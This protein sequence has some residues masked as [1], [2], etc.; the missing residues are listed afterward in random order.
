MFRPNNN[1]YTIE[2]TEKKILTGK[3]PIIWKILR[4]FVI[5]GWIGFLFYNLHIWKFILA[6]YGRDPSNFVFFESEQDRQ[7]Y[8]Q[9]Q[10]N[11]FNP[12][13]YGNNTWIE[14]TSLVD[15]CRPMLYFQDLFFDKIKPFINYSAL[16]ILV[17]LIIRIRPDEWKG[18][19]SKLKK[20]SEKVEADDENNKQT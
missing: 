14:R 8:K 18:M 1:I 13:L 6:E 4:L 5:L 7:D 3:G 2:M 15:Q 20:I 19:I 17:T 16:L 10:L 12:S 11:T 9:S